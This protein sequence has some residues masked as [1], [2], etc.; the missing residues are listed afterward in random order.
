MAKLDTSNKLIF[1]I[2]STILSILITQLIIHPA[3]NNTVWSCPYGNGNAFPTDCNYPLYWFFI[4]PILYL[5]I[6][7]LIYKLIIIFNRKHKN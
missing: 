4:A 2:S 7:I 1:I 6:A 5:F 3:L